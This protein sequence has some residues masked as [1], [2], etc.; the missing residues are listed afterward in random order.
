MTIV[1]EFWIA[2]VFRA[3]VRIMSISA[4]ALSG[5]MILAQPAIVR[6]SACC[7]RLKDS[8]DLWPYS[9]CPDFCCLLDHGVR[10]ENH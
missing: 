8:T 10:H 3:M 6:Y 1:R 2:L 5:Q 7:L 9:F 4:C